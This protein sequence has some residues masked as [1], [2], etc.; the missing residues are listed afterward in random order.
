MLG[1]HSGRPCASV[2]PLSLD[3]AYLDIAYLDILFGACSACF[4]PL[5]DDL[6]RQQTALDF[7]LILPASSFVQQHAKPWAFR[8]CTY[9]HTYNPTV[10]R[11]CN[12]IQSGSSERY[13]D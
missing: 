2:P 10:R 3:I 13:S 8:Y 9:V 4:L 12:R 7:C 6:S 1:I 11:R 5:E